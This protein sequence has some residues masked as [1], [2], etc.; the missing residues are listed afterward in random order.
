MTSFRHRLPLARSDSD[1]GD[2]R[3]EKDGRE[4]PCALWPTLPM[5][6]E[7]R[8]ATLQQIRRVL[9]IEGFSLLSL[10]DTIGP[11]AVDAVES[12]Y[13]C[14]GKVVV[15]GI[16]KSGYIAQKIS[17]TLASTGTPST[18][19][20]PVEALHG[21]LGRLSR[22]D[23]IIFVSNSG[24]GDEIR[25]LLPAIKRLGIKLIALTGA[26]DST[27]A[28]A[29]DV[30]LHVAVREEACPLGLAPTASTTAAL[31]VGDALAVAL[32]TKRGLKAEDYAIRHPGGT[33]GRRLRTVGEIM[34]TGDRVPVIGRD[35]PMKRV[36]L[37][38]STKRLGVV[39]VVDD[40]GAL[41]GCF[42]NGDLGRILER[43]TDIWH[44]KARDV[45]IENAKTIAAGRLGEDAVL[46]MQ[47]HSIT[48]L[49]IT[50]ERNKPVGIVHMHDLLRA[51]IV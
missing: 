4:L 32:L 26:K 9:E 11:S 20:H 45:M 37:E 1:R 31:A 14:T 34:L 43:G 7:Q 48:S 40:V 2:R 5:N 29:S 25:L 19:M 15:A 44:L 3:S 21:D 24:E 38:L 50:D 8:E 23:V 30:M 51:E 36:L 35:E 13:V 22:N 42:S 27:L 12:L 33:L 6:Q 49:F 39:A 16:G 17:S 41:C 10:V 46:K 28:K 18:F 47:Q